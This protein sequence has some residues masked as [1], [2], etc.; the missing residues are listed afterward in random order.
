MNFKIEISKKILLRLALFVA[1][2]GVAFLFDAYLDKNP[3]ELNTMQAESGK[4]ETRDTGGVYLIAQSSSLTL[5][6]AGEKSVQR[7]FQIQLHDK[8]LRKYHQKRNYQ[9]LK[10]ELATQSAPIIQSYHYLV[11]E[12]HFFPQPDEDNRA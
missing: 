9:V 3:A 10:A 8:F 6:T 12:N 1:L 4:H 2:I 5:K 11:F 7:K